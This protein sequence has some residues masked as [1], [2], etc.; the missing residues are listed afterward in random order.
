MIAVGR[1]RSAPW[2]AANR[3]TGPVRSVLALVVSLASVS[4]LAGSAHGAGALLPSTDDPSAYSQALQRHLD[5][6]VLPYWTSP[7]CL[8]RNDA[9][10]WAAE[11]GYP[12]IRL[13]RLLYVHGVAIERTDDDAERT[14]IRERYDT[15]F[16]DLL[17][18][19]R[20][21]ADGGWYA[22]TTYDGRSVLDAKKQ[23]VFYAY[24]VYV[25]ADLSSR[26]SDSRARRL[27]LETFG[28]MD[29]RAHDAESGGYVER[30][31]RP[32]ED[33][34]NA[35]KQLGTNM[36][37]A[38]ALAR[39]QTVAPSDL[40]RA[41]LRELC[42]ILMAHAIVPESGNAYM[43]YTRDWHG[44]T[45]GDNPTQQTLYGHNAELVWYVLDALDALG[46][47][48]RRYLPWLERVAEAVISGGIGPDGRTYTWGPLVGETAD[49]VNVRWWTSTEVLNMLARMYR[50][51][52]EERY[53]R[54]FSRVAHHTF[55]HFVRADD[56]QWFSDVNLADG[57]T[58]D[59]SGD[60]W[61]A[62]LHVTRMLVECSA[63]LASETPI[64][65]YPRA[66]MRPERAVQVEPG[67]AYFKDRSAASIVSEVV[68][69]GYDTIHLICTGRDPQPPC[70]VQAAHARGVSIWATFFPS[71]V[72]MPDEL[73]PPE[74]DRWRMRFTSDA[75]GGYRFFS[76][77][78]ED[79]LAWW[80]AHLARILAENDFDGVLFHEVHYPT[81]RDITGY[82]Q[83][84]FGDVSPGFVAAF[85]RA[86][87]RKDFPDFSDETSPSY[88]QSNADLYGDYVE[89]RVN[90][91]VHFLRELLDG[92]G[93][94]RRDHPGLRFASWTIAHSRADAL[95]LMRENEAQDPARL[96]AELRPDIHYLQSHYP[97]WGNR[98]Y[99]PDYIRGY[100]PYM[101]A[102]RSADPDL[103]IGVQADVGSTLPWRRDPEW[104]RGLDDVARDMGLASTTYYEFSVRWEVYFEPP[105]VYSASLDS[106]G[107]AEIVFD[108]RIDPASCTALEG[109]EVDGNILRFH[110]NG[111]SA[112]D[113]RVEVRIGGITDDPARRIPLGWAK[114][115]SIG[116]TN[117]IPEGTV[118][119]LTRGR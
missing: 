8:S 1:S 70:I 20:D 41:R 30:T 73:F 24:V 64:R 83:V 13:L 92:P 119:T 60:P 100:E 36:H 49:R 77:V 89:F 63:A 11:Y 81:L 52:R 21:P 17:S 31:D 39:L 99:G 79:Y 102:A 68:A 91:I 94:V 98:D 34:E 76:Y 113:G 75:L 38:L 26:I 14:G 88:Y 87:G 5:T 27:A 66:R 95:P 42:D 15:L 112:P 29:A 37:V 18:G 45:S 2:G 109:S 6:Q 54:L 44:T 116:P 33:P 40:V 50:L 46:E 51:T 108:Q 62:G 32:I 7:E 69:N 55:R 56:G 93:G 28:L 10:S 16:R 47:D 111:P 35:T 96:V 115:A 12:I 23:T 4:G 22:A 57:T 103:P 105:R 80:K 9:P 58:A 43:A 110:A 78:H 61:F 25:M 84:M 107:R 48:P 19:Y 114:D 3:G 82:G 117:R 53:L 86:T 67:F 104:M 118:I 106:H 65:H 59:G 101:D 72:Y 90:S 97:D 74:R 71:G 85:G